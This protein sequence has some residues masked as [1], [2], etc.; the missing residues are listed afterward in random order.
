MSAQGPP[1][2]GTAPQRLRVLVVD[3]SD[4]DATLEVRELV[5]H[6]FDVDHARV[7][8]PEALREVLRA[9]PWDVVLSDYSMPSFSGLRALEMVRAVAPEV[10]FILISGVIDQETALEAIRAGAQDYLLKDR[11]RRLGPAVER[12]V[13]QAQLRRER[14]EVADALNESAQRFRGYFSSPI[15]GMCITS[16]EKGWLEINDRLC[17]MLGYSRDELSA[18][19]LT[20]IT[21]PDDLPSD[22]RNVE[23]VV[24]GTLD[25]YTVEKRFI[26]KD[27]AVIWGDASAGVVRHPDGRVNYFV[28]LVNDITARK[29]MEA[30][31]QQIQEQLFQ[32]QK[33][34][35]V[36]R[37]AGG[38]AHDFNN[39][40][41]VIIG[42]A[43]LAMLQPISD[44]VRTD[45][46]EILKA[47]E[48]SANQTRQLLA[49]ARRQTIRPRVVDL[50]AS[51]AGL[52]PMLRRLV[53]EDI[54]LDCRPAA[55]LWKVHVDPSQFDQIVLNLVTNARDAI[56][57]VGRIV[58]ETGN[59]VLDGRPGLDSRDFVQLTVSDTGHGMDADT[60]K[61][62]FEPFFTTKGVGQ[63][64]GLGL[65]MVHGVVDQHKGLIGVTSSPGEGT[66]FKVYLPRVEGEPQAERSHAGQDVPR[67]NG[68]TILLVE[69]EAP[70]LALSAT[71][72]RRLNY[73]ILTAPGPEDALRLAREH[74]GPIDLL[75]SDVVMP[76]MNGGDL[77][78]AVRALRP[79]I[80]C[81]FV[82]G[83]PADVIANRGVLQDGV[84]FLQKPYSLD[85]LG[86]K[87]HLAVTSRTRA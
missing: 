84:H 71:A 29:A 46:Q 20:D 16:P 43:Q 53:G 9:G 52:L 18:L 4:L 74:Q 1:P 11:L 26:R 3:D 44:E 34:E 66:T 23:A 64:T 30:E 62:I 82:S 55:D 14:Q 45:L 28:V 31:R 49:F 50:N 69:D 22:I 15:V 10:P 70:L 2:G 63:G 7:D 67:G 76:R 21:H 38:V 75:V 5:R 81:L 48:R 54:E 36:G 40:L 51:L 59:V 79:D 87:I 33:M 6:G 25:H 85:D 57:G 42:H 77:A 61:H 8:G 47:A 12:E 80:P 39:M 83:Y 24:A 68:Q 65:A 17:E 27:G 19:S 32:A 35:S 37:L 13:R 58:I 86:R 73:S 78:E 56:A 72:L 60:V 41:G